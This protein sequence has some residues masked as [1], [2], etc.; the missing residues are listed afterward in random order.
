MSMIPKG[1][2]TIWGDADWS[3]EEGHACSKSKLAPDDRQ[4]SAKIKQESRVD[5]GPHGKPYA[6]YGRM[7]AFG[8]EA[9]VLSHSAVL[10][11]RKGSTKVWKLVYW[12]NFCCGCYNSVLVIL[13]H[14]PSVSPSFVLLLCMPM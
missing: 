3:P 5:I 2:N 1:G 7:V 4:G 11:K 6:H 14:S 8:K 12:Y 9:A 10:E 13:S